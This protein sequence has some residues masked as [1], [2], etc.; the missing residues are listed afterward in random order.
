M[1]EEAISQEL[2]VVT[3]NWKRQKTGFSLKTSQKE[4][5]FGLFTSRSLGE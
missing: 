5:H 4:T 2:Y 3:R 1:E